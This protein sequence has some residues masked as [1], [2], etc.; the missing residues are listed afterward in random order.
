[1]ILRIRSRDGT[2]RITV[3]NTTAS[4]MVADLQ[5]L[6]AATVTVPVPL[7]RHRTPPPRNRRPLFCLQEIFSE[8]D[9]TNAQGLIFSRSFQKTKEDKKW[10]HEVP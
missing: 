7:Q 10:C 5:R 6:I 4:I 9:E 1:M 2:E 3:E 8:L